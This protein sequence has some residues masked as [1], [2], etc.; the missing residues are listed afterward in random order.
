MKWSETGY[1]LEAPSSRRRTDDGLAKMLGE[2]LGG[3]SVIDFGC[4]DGRY[5]HDINAAGGN[6]R[7]YDGNPLTPSIAGDQCFVQDLSQP[8]DVGAADWV[9]SLETGE[10]V[11]AHFESNFIGNLH[12]HNR[13]GIVLS[14]AS[15]GQGGIGHINERSQNSL[16]AQI[17]RIGY[18]RDRETE[19][20]FRKVSRLPWFQRNIIVFRRSAQPN[21]PPSIE[22]HT[23][24]WNEE[25]LLPLFLSHYSGFACRIVVWDNGSDDRSHELIAD[26]PVSELRHFGKDHES[27]NSEYLKVKNNCWKSSDA[28]WV[29]VCD[30]DELVYHPDLKEF[31]RESPA[32]VH[33]CC[34]VRVT[35]PLTD[36]L[37]DMNSGV[38]GGA[39]LPGKAALFRPTI[40]EINYGVGCHTAN[41]AEPIQSTSGIHLLHCKHI[42]GEDAL[43][44]RSRLIAARKCAED[45]ER[46]WGRQYFFPEEKTR[47][48]HRKFENNAVPISQVIRGTA[49]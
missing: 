28:D 8:V 26:C 4:G 44:E 16:S 13:H 23:I 38:W 7:G 27:S 46:G 41:P 25:D 6:C 2:F 40:R 32:D 14:W 5:V 24:C 9:L 39:P 34:G 15:P 37:P 45:I 18:E 42:R 17:E 19:R 31:L 47:A 30:V 35:G 12:R 21:P 1:W 20:D 33:H 11:P 22:V 3:Y 48:L 10:H 29:I 49:K 36:R 43:V